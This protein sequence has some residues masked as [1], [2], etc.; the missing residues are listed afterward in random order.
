MEWETYRPFAIACTV[1]V[2]VY[3]LA[4]FYVGLREYA[5]LRQARKRLCQQRAQDDQLLRTVKAA[6]MSGAV[7][8]PIATECA[9]PVPLKSGVLREAA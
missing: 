5:R 3:V 9:G 6:R 4:T 8:L 1:L 7:A 2:G